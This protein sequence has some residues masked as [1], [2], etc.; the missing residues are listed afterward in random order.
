[1]RILFVGPKVNLID[2][3]KSFGAMWSFCLSRALEAEGVVVVRDGFG[4]DFNQNLEWWTHADLS[5]FDHIVAVSR[6]FSKYPQIA[7]IAKLKCHGVVSQVFDRAQPTTKALTFSITVPT[8]REQDRSAWVG[9]AADAGLF[10]T[11]QDERVLRILIDHPLYGG[12]PDHSEAIIFDAIMFARSGVWENGAWDG[13]RIR[14]IVDG[15]FEDVKRL[16]PPKT[17]HRNHVSVT[18]M[19]AEYAKAHVFIPTHSESVGL[20]VL[21]AAI[22]GAIP[23]VR[24]DYIKRD[25]LYSVPHVQYETAIPWDTVLRSIDPHRTRQLAKRHDWASVAKRVIE[26]LNKGRERWRI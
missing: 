24:L 21:E 14:T 5:T 4:M 19:A 17:F 22:S 18:A 11:N 13:V 9:W 10:T 8:I 20:A 26:N 16:G 7:E 25:L 3:V 15:G 12:R 6:F 23:V 1:M 2:D